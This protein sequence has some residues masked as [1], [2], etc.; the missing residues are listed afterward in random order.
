[1]SNSRLETKM[2]PHK[3]YQGVATVA[4]LDGPP[5]TPAQ[6]TWVSGRRARPDSR[7]YPAVAG[8]G[9]EVNVTIV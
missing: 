5:W 1:M 9:P 6:V 7:G 3:L 2:R 4:A 8:L